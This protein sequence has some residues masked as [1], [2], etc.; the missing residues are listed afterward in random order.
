MS[1]ESGHDFVVFPARV[2]LK[3][4]VANVALTHALKEPSPASR[5]R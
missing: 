3:D 1:S 5:G 4:D 2:V